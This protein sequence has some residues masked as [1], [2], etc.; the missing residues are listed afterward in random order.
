[1]KITMDMLEY[2]SMA[3]IWITCGFSLAYI[4]YAEA[5]RRWLGFKSRREFFSRYREIC[6]RDRARRASSMQ[7]I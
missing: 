1:M 2:A 7:R 4:G 5:R 6:R 3:T